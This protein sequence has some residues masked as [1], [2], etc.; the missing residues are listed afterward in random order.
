[1]SKHLRDDLRKKQESIEKQISLLECDDKT[2]KL[3]WICVLIVLSTP[4]KEKEEKKF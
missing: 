1:L 3:V 2:Q 4:A